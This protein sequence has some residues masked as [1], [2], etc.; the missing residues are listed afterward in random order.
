MFKFRVCWWGR[1]VPIA[2]RSQDTARLQT[3]SSLGASIGIP[4]STWYL[5]RNEYANDR[6]IGCRR[7]FQDDG[8][9]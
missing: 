5:D 4:D 7:K 3:D 8:Q 9:E 6:D 1:C 2:S